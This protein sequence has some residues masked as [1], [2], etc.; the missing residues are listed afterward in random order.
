LLGI[1]PIF[2]VH[3]VKDIHRSFG[4]VATGTG[5]RQ[6]VPGVVPAFVLRNDVIDRGVFVA[7]LAVAVRTLPIPVL[8]NAF[9]KAF[10][11]DLWAEYDKAGK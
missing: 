1:V 8:E 2:W 9:T 4:F 11:G 7:Q 3:V 5:T 10:T 6:V